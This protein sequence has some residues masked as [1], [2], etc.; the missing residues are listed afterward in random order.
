[1]S[2]N[3]SSADLAVLSDRVAEFQERSR[4]LNRELSGLEHVEY[5]DR[6]GFIGA[7][8][9]VHGRLV[10]LKIS[11]EAHESLSPEELGARIVA[12]YQRGTAAVEAQV[13]VRT[14]AVYGAGFTL[15]QV[16][17]GEVDPAEILAAARQRLRG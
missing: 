11:D 5:D 7:Q 13:L 3:R 10:K 4:E 8:L 1:M 9:D 12:V 6:D 14:A 2:D 16:R 17:R 15:G